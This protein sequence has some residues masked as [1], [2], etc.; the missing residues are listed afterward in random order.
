MI[1]FITLL[2]EEIETQKKIPKYLELDLNEYHA[3]PP[4]D[5]INITHAAFMLNTPIVC[6]SIDSSLKPGGILVIGDFI[7]TIEN[8][9]K[10]FPNY[11]VLEFHM[12]YFDNK[13]ANTA[14]IVLK[15]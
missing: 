8:M 3:L 7:K 10:Y 11:T 15:K 9:L 4:R 12:G 5:G 14:V 13:N 2:H 1:K 6:K